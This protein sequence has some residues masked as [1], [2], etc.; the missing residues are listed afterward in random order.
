MRWEVAAKQMDLTRCIKFGAGFRALRRAR[1]QG[2]RGLT[3]NMAV[4]AASLA[5]LRGSFPLAFFFRLFFF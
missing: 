5:G 4:V 1:N 3:G 2:R